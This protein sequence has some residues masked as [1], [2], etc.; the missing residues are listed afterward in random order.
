MHGTTMKK[1]FDCVLCEAGTGYFYTECF[2]T[3]RH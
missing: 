1:K 2:T 3:C